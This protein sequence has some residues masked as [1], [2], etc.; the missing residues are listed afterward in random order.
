M[1]QK[2]RK[3]TKKSLFSSFLTFFQP[4]QYNYYKWEI[5]TIFNRETPMKT[6]CKTLSAIL[7]ALYSCFGTT[8]CMEETRQ[9]SKRSL[10]KSILN[11]TTEKRLT[12]HSAQLIDKSTKSLVGYI[13][14][15]P[16]KNIAIQL[17][18]LSQDTNMG[19]GFS[20]YANVRILQE[21]RNYQE[22]IAN[23]NNQAL[24]EYYVNELK[25]SLRVRGFS[26]TRIH[27]LEKTCGLSMEDFFGHNIVTYNDITLGNEGTRKDFGTTVN[28]RL[29]PSEADVI[30]WQ[31][32][33]ELAAI[34]QFY[35]FANPEANRQLP[36]VCIV[37]I[38][39]TGG[40][41]I[42]TFLEG[43]KRNRIF[44]ILFVD[45][46]Q[47]SKGELVDKINAYDTYFAQWLQEMPRYF[48]RPHA[49]PQPMPLTKPAPTHVGL[50]LATLPRTEPS[51][52]EDISKPI[53]T[54]LV[55][56][57]IEGNPTSVVNSFLSQLQQVDHRFNRQT[58][59]TL[60]TNKQRNYANRRGFLLGLAKS[61][62]DAVLDALLIF[63]PGKM[64]TADEQQLLNETRDQLL[65]R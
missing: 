50:P 17:R 22:L 7:F 28:Y 12:E 61:R 63:A 54:M 39:T 24:I 14:Q 3:Y 29:F 2:K 6:Y 25:Q 5:W 33:G 11:N 41:Y 55:N 52:A 4:F 9:P 13:H 46:V 60:T 47:L 15:F 23:L 31:R 20:T 35:S 37:N 42:A 27:K 38:G 8:F 32:F 40:H 49:A 56:A 57:V 53:I 48:G 45:S 30:S 65:A 58:P 19:C 18:G 36:S 51:A 43:N 64:L 21:A 44:G 34:P 26:D 59:L 62:K 16:G 10:I 1:Y